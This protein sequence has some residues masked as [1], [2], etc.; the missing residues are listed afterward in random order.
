[1]WEVDKNFNFKIYILIFS[2]RGVYLWA[3]ATT[4]M[5]FDDDDDDD[6]EGLHVGFFPRALITWHHKQNQFFSEILDI[7]EIAEWRVSII[8]PYG[9]PQ[10]SSGHAPRGHVFSWKSFYQ[11]QQPLKTIP[12]LPFSLH[13]TLK[14]MGRGARRDW[15][16]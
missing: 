15:S 12:F 14:Q 3:T 6:D 13:L 11:L 10:H 4:T 9:R 1:M 7:S 2:F 8:P 16:A 5:I